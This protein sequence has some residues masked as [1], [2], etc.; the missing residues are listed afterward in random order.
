M[1]G[2]YGPGEGTSKTDGP[3]VIPR[4]PVISRVSRSLAPLGMT[5]E[6][7]STQKVGIIERRLHRQ[8]RGDLAGVA[9]RL[10][11]QPLQEGLALRRVE[12]ERPVQQVP[13]PAEQHRGASQRPSRGGTA[14]ARCG[15]L[16]GVPPEAGQRGGIDGTQ[17]L[18]WIR[19]H[20]PEAATSL[21]VENA[22][23]P[24]PQAPSYVPEQSMMVP[25][26]GAN[27]PQKPTAPGAIPRGRRPPTLS[28]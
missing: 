26:A 21:A 10:P 7:D 24:R 20:R 19:K 16:H 15:G 9:R 18:S 27:A 22:T 3:P 5:A 11:R 25:P 13:E 2:T 28:T 1:G 23:V 6:G 17:P 12:I 8:Q 14:A 4:G